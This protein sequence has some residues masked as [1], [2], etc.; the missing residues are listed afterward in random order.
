MDSLGKARRRASPALSFAWTARP[1]QS[2]RPI[3][4]WQTNT[5]TFLANGTN[6][7]IEVASLLPGAMLDSF[8]L[9]ELPATTFLPEEPFTPFVGRERAGR[10]EARGGGPPRRRDQRTRHRLRSGGSSSSRSRRLWSRP[11]P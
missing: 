11:S 1:T 9:L 5:L 8:A 2:S 10:L 3:P 7:L 4:L 6:A